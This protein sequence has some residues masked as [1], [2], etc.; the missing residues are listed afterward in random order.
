MSKKA[1]LEL[2][3]EETMENSEVEVVKTEPVK[4]TWSLKKKLAVAGAALLGL[5]IGAFALTRKGKSA[6]TASDEDEF[7][8]DDDIA[9]EDDTDETAEST[10]VTQT[11]N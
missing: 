2:V 10:E 6:E 7:C 1:N 4:K 3:K 9:D 5:G 11:E 8:D